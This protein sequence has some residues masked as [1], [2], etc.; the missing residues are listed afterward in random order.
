MFSTVLLDYLIIKSSNLYFFFR[1]PI[2]NSKSK[3]NFYD[4]FF[5][6]LINNLS[7]RIG[8][9]TVYVSFTTGHKVFSVAISQNG[10]KQENTIDPFSV[11]SVE[12][13]VSHNSF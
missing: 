5:F 8:I 3:I 2:W 1:P 9:R 4:S 12:C 6:F 13:A 10:K 7:F 11:Y